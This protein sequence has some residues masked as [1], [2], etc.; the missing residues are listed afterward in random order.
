MAA[1][2]LQRPALQAYPFRP[3]QAAPLPLV[4]AAERLPPTQVAA[5]LPR[6]PEP[7]VAAG[8]P[9]L[10]AAEG[11]PPTAGAARLRRRP[12]QAVVLPLQEAGVAAQPLPQPAAFHSGEEEQAAEPTLLLRLPVSV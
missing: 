10:V 6:R 5:R 9:L 2:P 12:E 3:E 11:L 1:A 7:A 4:E 8:L